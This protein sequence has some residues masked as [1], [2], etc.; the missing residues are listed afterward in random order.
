MAFKMN[1]FSGFKETHNIEI[2]ANDPNAKQLITDEQIGENR[3]DFFKSQEQLDFE[4][5][6]ID[7][8]TGEIKKEALVTA[9]TAGPI[10]ASRK[11]F[12]TVFNR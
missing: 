5:K 6:N 2:S 12:K 1:G 3:E 11:I 10:D 9:G 4:R 8:E 7:P